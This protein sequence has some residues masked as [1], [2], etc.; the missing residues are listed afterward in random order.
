M[1]EE[2]SE[3]FVWPPE[4]T[5][6]DRGEH[7]W[8]VIGACGIRNAPISPCILQ[9]SSL[10]AQHPPRNPVPDLPHSPRSIR[11]I[12][13]N[14]PEMTTSSSSTSTYVSGEGS[15]VVGDESKAGVLLVYSWELRGTQRQDSHS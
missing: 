10:Y 7:E 3:R 15:D 5:Q 1:G 2:R 11:G 9:V 14:N 8:H 12:K 6:R 4:T 13:Q